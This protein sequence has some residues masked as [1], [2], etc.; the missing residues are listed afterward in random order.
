MLRLQVEVVVQE[1]MQGRQG[2]VV[3]LHPTC[4]SAGGIGGVSNS[5]CT[6]SLSCGLCQ[7]LSD[8]SLQ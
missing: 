6:H 3:C 4:H 2:M 7:S 8:V 1:R 5:T